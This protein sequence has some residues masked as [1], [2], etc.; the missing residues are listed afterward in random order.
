M[1]NESTEPDQTRLSDKQH[2]AINV[3]LAGGTH[4]DAAKAA[5]VARTTVTE[6]VNHH[7]E[8]HHE[9]ERRRYQRAEQVNDR[10]S[11]LTTR[12]LDV[13]EEHVAA[14]D[15]RAALGILRLLPRDA[16]HRKP[17][18]P[19]AA[20][21]QEDVGALFRARLAQL[22]PMPDRPASSARDA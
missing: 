12:S 15:L 7:S 9:L 18:P 11:E 21:Q 10:V 2:L 14:G 1:T 4:R 13:I 20:G 6:W 3:L 5:G 8:F 16:I 22:E 17:K 19:H